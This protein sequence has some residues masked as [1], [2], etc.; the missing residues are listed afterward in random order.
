MNIVGLLR[1]RSLGNMCH[2]QLREQHSKHWLMMTVQYL[3]TCQPTAESAMV[4]SATGSG[5][6]EQPALPK[7]LLSIYVRDVINRLDDVKARLTSV[8][9]TIIKIDLMKK[10]LLCCLHSRDMLFKHVLGMQIY[11]AT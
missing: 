8:F 3:T 1:V 5:P 7:Y 2:K 11:T 9:S 10:V 4:T 6:P